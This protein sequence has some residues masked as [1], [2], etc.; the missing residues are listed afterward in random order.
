MSNQSNRSGQGQFS[1]SSGT[2]QSISREGRLFPPP[3]EFAATALIKDPAVYDRLYKRS[4]EEPEAFW[5]EMA[6]TEL[7]WS[8]PWTKVLD[9]QLPWAKWFDGGEINLSANCQARPPT[10]ARPC[11]RAWPDGGPGS[12]RTG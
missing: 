4:I 10:A 7:T 2:I 3:P 9:W 11:S 12:W 6:V 5:S 1:D 8:K